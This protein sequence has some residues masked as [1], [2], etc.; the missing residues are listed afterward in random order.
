MVPP[1]SD[2]ESGAAPCR[3]VVQKPGTDPPLP[4]D[5]FSLASCHSVRHHRARPH[6]RKPRKGGRTFAGGAVRVND[7]ALIHRATPRGKLSAK[8]RRNRSRP[9]AVSRAQSG[10]RTARTNHLPQQSFVPRRVFAYHDGVCPRSSE[11]RAPASGAGGAGSSPAGGTTPLP[12]GAGR[13]AEPVSFGVRL[14]GAH[15][16]AATLPHH[17]G[18]SGGPPGG[19]HLEG[20]EPPCHSAIN[21][22]ANAVTANSIRSRRP[23][24]TTGPPPSIGGNGC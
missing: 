22:N 10:R 24:M 3:K 17:S 20:S 12:A 2:L 13:R 7:P 21:H 5:Q 11:D 23:A 1:Q 8:A 14:T 4:V 9:T 18:A 15:P 6:Q 19:V 16:A